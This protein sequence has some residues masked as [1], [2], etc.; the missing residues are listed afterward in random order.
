MAID[1][2]YSPNA[3]NTGALLMTSFDSKGAAIYFNLMKQVGWDANKKVASFSGGEKINVKLSKDEAGALMYAVLN[4]GEASFYHTFEK[5]V[6]TV[7]FKYYTIPAN[8]DMKAKVGFG[9]TVKSG[10]K[11]W[12]VGLTVGAAMRLYMFLD[13][14]FEHINSAAYAAD[15]KAYEERVAAQGKGGAKAPAKTQEDPA[16]VDPTPADTDGADF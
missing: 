15:K 10:D 4:N 1:S 2:F 3:K 16:A 6:T 7:S 9:L 5:A 14:A 8:G 13:Y 12:K 11:E